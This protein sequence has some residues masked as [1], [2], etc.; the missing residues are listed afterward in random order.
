[1]LKLGVIGN[2]VFHSKSPLIFHHLSQATGV[3]LHYNRISCESPT[4]AINFAKDLK[5]DGFNVTSPFKRTIIEHLNRIDYQANNLNSSNTVVFTDEYSEGYNTDY[6]GVLRTIW[7]N[8]LI[9]NKKRVLILGAGAAAQTA[10]FAIKNMNAILSIWSRNQQKAEKA[11]LDFD[12]EQ[13][14]TEEL[15]KRISSFDYIV[16]T[17]PPYSQILRELSFTQHQT[18]FDTVYHQSFFAENQKHYGYQ[19]IH[20][21]KWLINQALLSFELFAERKAE[22]P[23]IE[24]YLEKYQNVKPKAFILVGF[25]GSG[26]STLGEIVA[27]EFGFNFIDLDKEIENEVHFTINE[28]FLKSGEKG[29]RLHESETLLK[30]KENIFNQK[31]ITILS[32]GGGIL[33]NEQ[34]INLLKEIG[35]IIWIY[36]PFMD[37]FSRISSLSNR[38]LI[39]HEENALELYEKRKEKYFFNSEYIF[40]NTSS[41]ESAVLRLSNEIKRLL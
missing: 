26:K 13:I 9:F 24:L 6:F 2:P 36:S 40:L 41:V 23:K 18:I 19:L 28:I 7:N 10:V 34:N 33:E 11:A 32:V 35:S 15:K 17:I 39:Q 29:F 20:G 31:G 21:E 12:I 8:N 25:S 14:S 22:D 38:P 30:I 4:D 37:C 1:M 16:S 5:I 27:N 3:Q